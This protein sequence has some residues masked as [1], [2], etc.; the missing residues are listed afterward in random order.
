MPDTRRK[1]SATE[2][3]PER[4]R[5]SLLK[6]KM[7][8][9]ASLRFS[10]FLE[11]E[12]TLMLTNCSRVKSAGAF[13]ESCCVQPRSHRHAS[14]RA[15]QSRCPKISPGRL[16]GVEISSIA[17]EFA[18]SKTPGDTGVETTGYFRPQR[19]RGSQFYVLLL[20]EILCH[21][22]EFEIARGPIREPNISG[23]VCRG[24]CDLV[25]IA[26]LCIQARPF[27]KFIG[28]AQTH[29]LHG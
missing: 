5:S 16:R 7:A 19:L 21:E 12:V 9:A 8:A 3:A 24:A 23:D 2:V 29:L 15:K 27:R 26:K 11:T 17:G 14:A 25:H 1:A 18:G 6:T 10:S 22:R 13:V 20:K 4:R 28:R